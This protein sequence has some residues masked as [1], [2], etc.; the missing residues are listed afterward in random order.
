MVASAVRRCSKWAHKQL[1]ARRGGQPASFAGA[2]GRGFT[3]DVSADRTVVRV[4]DPITLTLTLR[5]AGSLQ[6]AGLPP[7]TAGAGLLPGQFR[8]RGGDLGGIIQDDGSKVF[9]TSIKVLDDSVSEIPSLAYSWFD[10]ERSGYE[11]TY[12]PPIALSVK[13]A[14]VVGADSVVTDASD[15]ANASSSEDGVPSAAGAMPRA[16]PGRITLEGAELSIIRG[17]GVLTGPGGR[18]GGLPTAVA[19]HL[20]PL[21]LLGLAVIGRR[22]ADVDPAIRQR[23]RRVRERVAAVERQ[24]GRPRRAALEAITGALRS[25]LVEIPAARTTVIDAFI[26]EC[27]TVL[28]SPTADASTPIGD[29]LYERARQHARSIAEQVD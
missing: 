29:D 1:L 19:L 6:S 23:R 17:A 12:S 28:F 5:G 25:L 22:R 18:L 16:V 13:R 10:T 20:V 26:A 2:V 27:E 9:T 3:L 24:R 15:P 11:T 14:E 8:A 4:G 21:V 7:L